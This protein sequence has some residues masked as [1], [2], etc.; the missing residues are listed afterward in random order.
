MLVDD[1][2][3][4]RSG[5]KALL[6]KQTS[7]S[8]VSENATATDAITRLGDTEVDLVLM[9]IGLPD[10]D[11]LKATQIVKQQFP[12]V[13]VIVLTMHNDEPYL[14][15][16]LEAGAS[17]YVL[18]EAA[19]TELVD[20]IHTVMRGE[21]AIHTSMVHII[22]NKALVDKDEPSRSS[23]GHVLTPRE[24]E[25]LQYVGLGYTHSEIAD[26]LVVSVKTVEKHKVH[27]M[28]KLKLKR[29]HELVE[30]AIKNGFVSLEEKR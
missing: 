1:H 29:R 17:G 27:I 23:N 18:K 13:Q 12:A 9:D 10:M 7:F 2:T 19:S 15:K 22:V 6:E 20:A 14:L 30:Y 24:Q 5:L 25:V 3:L 8:I 16:A 4:F 11:G 26:I 28:G 21:M